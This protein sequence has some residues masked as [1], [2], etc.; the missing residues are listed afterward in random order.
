M[1]RLFVHIPKNGGMTIR[2]GIPGKILTAGEGRQI[3]TAYT[4]AVRQTMDADGE[5]H[6]FEHC[7]IRYWRKD[8]RRDRRAFAIVRNPWDRVVSRYLFAKFHNDPCGDCSFS[9]FLS[10]RNVY[11]DRKYYWHRAIKGW[12]PQT[13]YVMDRGKLACDI[14]RFGTSDVEDYFGLAKPLPVRNVTNIERLDYRDFYGQYEHDVVAEWYVD[15]IDF[16]GF[17]FEGGATRNLWMPL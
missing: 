12:Y 16:F 3:S 11:G 5:H 6:G 17:T 14:L 7:P 4:N 15:D 9:E 2:K 1:K 8:L 13:Y 10:Q